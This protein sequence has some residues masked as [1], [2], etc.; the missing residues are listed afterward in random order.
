MKEVSKSDLKAKMFD[1]FRAVEASSDALV[2]T[3]FG[4]PKLII[5]KYQEAL[6]L[7]ELFKPL[8]AKKIKIKDDLLLEQTT[9]EREA[10]IG[11]R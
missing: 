4:K 6:P 5:Y 10:L 7:G 9:A 1:Y 11:S 8:R 2:V 3:D